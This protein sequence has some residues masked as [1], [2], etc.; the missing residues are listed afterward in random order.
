M[1]KITFITKNNKYVTAPFEPMM[2]SNTIKAIISYDN[3]EDFDCSVLENPIP[4]PEV[5]DNILNI[6]IEYCDYYHNN[7]NSEEENKIFDDNFIKIDDKI[8]FNLILAANYLEI[9]NLLDLG[10]KTVAN[11]IKACSTP[12]E[13]R[14]RFGICNDFTPSEEEEI[15]KE[16]AWC[17]EN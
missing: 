14:H 10:C 2:Q 11:Y 9:N 3:L 15:I 6:I 7:N 5:E 1:S 17:A 13:I 8:L 4:I 12:Q 16:N